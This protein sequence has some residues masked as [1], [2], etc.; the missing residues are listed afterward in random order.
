M[1]LLYVG[2]ASNLRR[3]IIGNHLRRSG[4]S[5]LRR[6][7]AGLLLTEQQYRTERTDRVVLVAEDEVRLTAWMHTHLRL[8][9]WEHPNPAAIEPAVIGQWA[10]PLNHDHTSSGAVRD[11]VKA[12]RTAY[13]TSA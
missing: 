5:T 4:S 12:A 10:P 1:R 8:S 9:W 13:N 6:T 7:L 2:I 11:I 3:R